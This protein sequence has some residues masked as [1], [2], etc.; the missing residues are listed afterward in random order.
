MKKT[1]LTLLVFCAAL[2]AN[3]Q[4]QNDEPTAILQHGDQA[5]VYTGVNAFQLAYNAAAT[6]DVITLSAGT[7]NAPTNRLSK[8]LSIYGAGFEMDETTGTDKTLI[9]GKLMLESI[10]NALLE[11]LYVQGDIESVY[12][13]TNTIISRC[14]VTGKITT[15]AITDSQINQC[16]IGGVIASG[17]SN[18]NYVATNLHVSNSSIS[19]IGNFGAPN[20]IYIDHCLVR[21]KFGANVN[22]TNNPNVYTNCIFTGSGTYTAN[23]A[24]MT[25]CIYVDESYVNPQ[26]TLTNC[27]QVDLDDIFADGEN[28]DYSVE[29]TYQ[30][31]QPNLWVGTDGTPIGPSGGLG[32]IK[33]PHTPVVKDLQLN[34]EGVTLNINYEAEP[35]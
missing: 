26:A 12:G 23:G 24:L 29:R 2:M 19:C 18:G 4:A 21:D 5:T 28:A 30:L 6:G 20:S 27:Y 31:Q 25:N 9:N 11:G 14:Y 13:M 22:S 16:Y 17:G 34:V 10:N 8:T 3:A 35:R 32:W 7:F 15:F 33:Y 1:I